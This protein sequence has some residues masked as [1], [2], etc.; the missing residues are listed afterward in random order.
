MSWV[1]TKRKKVKTEYG[2][3]SGMT[4]IEVIVAIVL[5]TILVMGILTALT[6]QITLLSRS[7]DITITSFSNQSEVEEAIENIKINS[8]FS[9]LST[10]KNTIND[11][12]TIS[13][14]NDSI[15]TEGKTGNEVE[16]YKMQLVDSKGKTTRV[17]LSPSLASD[18]NY[19]IALE[20]K[21]VD[22]LVDND[23]TKTVAL[24]TGSSTPT[25]TGRYTIEGSN[26]YAS[27]CKWYAS[28]PG[29]INPQW[30][31]DYE[32][33]LRKVQETGLEPTYGTVDLQNLT[34]Y[35]NR[36]VIFTVQ[37]ADGNGI[38]GAEVVSKSIL[39]QGVEWKDGN[40]PWADKNGNF[41]FDGFAVDKDAQLQ[42]SMI[43]GGLD[44]KN[45]EVNI[46]DVE[47]MDIKNSSLFIPRAIDG[48][49]IYS[50]NIY[51][52]VNTGNDYEKD[53]VTTNPI[54]WKIENGIHF[55]N[56]IISD[57]QV[58]LKTDNGQ[59]VMYRFVELDTDGKAVL[60]SGIPRLK[61]PGSFNF[62]DIY[63]AGPRIYQNLGSEIS[64]LNNIY[65]GAYGT[66][67]GFI[68]LQPF[69]SI[70]GANILLEAEEPIT[71]YNSAM[72]LQPLV[73]D[74]SSMNREITLNSIKDISIRSIT[75]L[76]PNYI[77]GNTLTKSTII[78]N[79]NQ[80]ISVEN[81][82]F[83]DID[84]S[85][86]GNSIFRGV[87][88]SENRMLSVKDGVVLTLA[89]LSDGTKVNNIG[90]LNLGNTGT[91]K[92]ANSMNEDLENPLELTLIDIGTNQMNITSN[93][94]RNI[95]YADASTSSFVNGVFQNIGSGNTNL[96]YKI[97]ITDVSNVKDIQV[98]FDG[99]QTLTVTGTLNNSAIPVSAT[100][101]VRDKY[102]KDK[103]NMPVEIAIPKPITITN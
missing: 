52:N 55:A 68:Y 83:K 2:Q 6:N 93:Y 77:K 39:I 99:S 31:H 102:I 85:L 37:P 11:Y 53:I 5:M 101:T 13:N 33:I 38:R 95:G 10:W 8:K 30:P 64:S 94:G 50:N 9:N 15:A 67:K 98:S 61:N 35:A 3:Y 91:V 34:D 92:F 59:I 23:S 17:Y 58:S 36:Y 21:E 62:E 74:N 42:Y 29:V 97:D 86:L 49:N 82:I 76:T 90:N 69:S 40:F 18:E 24:I 103:N 78:F 66:G 79:T 70:N 48:Q 7:K 89:K 88:W 19:M 96:E 27:V 22:I 63:V 1:H 72:T 43:N 14:R 87:S 12:S 41:I 73:G 47:K 80:N 28:I 45:F 81:T 71:I 100:L 84:V 4:L 54:D 60:D 44:Y 25:V 20:A 56:K 46:S 57:N 65:L 16:L 51:L 75:G 26:Y 32:Q